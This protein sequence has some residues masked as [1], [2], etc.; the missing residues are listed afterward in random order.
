MITRRGGVIQE[1][2]RSTVRELE[3]YCRVEA[4]GLLGY[5]GSRQ[6]CCQK[7]KSA[8]GCPICAPGQRPT[9][10]ESL[11]PFHMRQYLP[12]WAKM[13]EPPLA[14]LAATGTKERDWRCLHPLCTG[15]EPDRWP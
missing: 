12:V 1:V 14:Q 8:H 7:I 9:R 13:P 15:H 10:N 11:L 4:R 3:K 2:T 6:T 5:P